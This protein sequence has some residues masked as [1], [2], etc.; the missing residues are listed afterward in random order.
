MRRRRALLCLVLCLLLTGCWSRVEVNDLGVVL[1]L[2]ADAGE[3]GRMRVTLFFA[4]SSSA[5]GG[6]DGNNQ[7]QGAE[8]QAWVV[9][10]EAADVTDAIAKIALASSRRISLHHLQVILVGEGVGRQGIRGLEDFVARNPQI[11]L[12][13]RPFTVLGRAQTVLE[14]MPA[15]KGMQPRNLVDLL[16]ATG[17]PRYSLKEYLV[18][19]SSLTHSA[20]MHG[21]RLMT[22]PGGLPGT[23]DRVVALNGAAL[24]RQDKLVGWL[25]DYTTKGFYWL[26]GEGKE[27]V[28]TGKCP[29]GTGETFSS[30]ALQTRAS[31]KPTLAGTKLTFFVR[32]QAQMELLRVGCKQTAMDDPKSR[33]TIQELLNQE[34]EERA[35]QA[36]AVIKETKT[37][38]VGFGKRV[39]LAYPAYW[40]TIKGE[41]WLDV[42]VDSKVTVSA[43]I[44]LQN[45]GLLTTSATETRVEMDRTR[46]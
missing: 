32:M 29:D 11:R 27:S 30:R 31:I 8:S 15:F 10:Q 38:P 43:D 44:R 12:T 22:P 24:Y 39:E 6:A 28:L 18:A 33:Q 21:L 45:A 41:R 37:D 26:L 34:I 16:D 40:Q 19:R 46:P 35:V 14:T 9:T 42:W 23:P 25:D 5:G 2:G 1:A 4:R 7:Q 3:E 13:A 17:V 36:I 20:W